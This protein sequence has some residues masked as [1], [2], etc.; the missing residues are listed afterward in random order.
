MDPFTHI[1]QVAQ[2]FFLHAK[3][4]HDW[5]HT[6]RVRKLCSHIGSQER[7]DLEILRYAAI[8][9]DLGRSAQDQAKGQLCH[10]ELSANFACQILEKHQVDPM[11]IAKI[12][13]CIESHRF[14]GRIAPHSKEA[15]I[16]FDADKLDSIGAVGIGRAFLFA[17]EIGARLHNPH[18]DLEKTRP[19]TREDTAFR[20]YQVKLSKVKDRML[21]LE[22]KRIAN[23]RH[24]FM[25]EFFDRLNKEV[26][27]E[28]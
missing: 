10:A 18:V 4:S 2:Q 5:D 12:V 27:G 25:V 20:E 17:G 8:L 9:H 13:H 22:G 7:A 24:R 15:Q 1:T 23:E 16:L 3:G 26:E 21:T 19:Y 14:R 6:D 28:L 11:K